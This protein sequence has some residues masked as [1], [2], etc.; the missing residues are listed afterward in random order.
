[1]GLAHFC[2]HM[3]FMGSTKYPDINHYANYMAQNN[4][5][6]NAY[7]SHEQTNFYFEINPE[8]LNPALDIFAQFFISPLFTES[9]TDLEVIYFKSL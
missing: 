6:F 2:E 7:T 8:N 5:E 1:M 4:G 9:A 3:V